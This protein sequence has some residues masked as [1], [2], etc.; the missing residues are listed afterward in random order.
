[1]TGEGVPDVFEYIAK[2]VINRWDYIEQMEARKLHM[3]EASAAETI[4]LRPHASEGDK[5]GWNKCC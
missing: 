1:M 5:R 4:R 2:R 3:R